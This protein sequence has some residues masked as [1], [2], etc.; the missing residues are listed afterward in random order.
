MSKASKRLRRE[1]VSAKKSRVSDLSIL[2][3]GATLLAPY[4]IAQD[5][6]AAATNTADDEV[7]RR[8]H[9]DPRHGHPQ[10]SR[11]IAG[12]QERSR[13]RGRLDH[14]VR[15]RRVPRQER[16]RSPAARDRHHRDAVRRIRRH[17]ALLRRAFGRRSS[18]ACR[19]CAANS[20]AAT[21][22]TRTARAACRSATSRPSSWRASTP[23][24]TATADMIEGGI[25]GTVNLRTH[26]PF[27]SEGFV[28]AFSG[29]LGY[30]DLSEEAK[31]SGSLI[32]S[33]RWDTG[34]GEFGLMANA[35][36]SAGHHR[37]AGH[38]ARCASS[39][40]R[41]SPLTA[42]APSGSRAASTF[43]TTPT[44]ARARVRRS[45][46]QW[47]SPDDTLLATVAVQPFRV[48]K[49]LGRVFAERRHRQL[50][51]SRRASSSRTQFAL[52]PPR[53]R[54]PY[55]FDSRGVFM[56][57][58]INDDRCLGR[59]PTNNPYLQHPNGFPANTA[60]PA[61]DSRRTAFLSWGCTTAWDAPP[62]VAPATGLLPESPRA[63]S[64]SA[65]TRASRRRRTPP[66]TLSLNLRGTSPKASASTSTS[67]RSIRRSSISTTARTTR[68]RTDL[69]LDISPAASRS[70]EFRAPRATA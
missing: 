66:K 24:R 37:I 25:A 59:A 39:A 17:H 34:I 5:Q 41:T 9:R 58:V 21:A 57:G 22:S 69:D 15:H 2:A 68:P 51:D 67:R 49:Q 6:D 18:A 55:E 44:T 1:A 45:P 31:P 16:R 61:P 65:P 28:V 29:E 46:R 27:D 4:A 63:A 54:R 30:G 13:H 35:A 38:A 52:R 33:N 12:N 60:N 62:M 14:R 7:R 36:Y 10:G 26:V 32:V 56:S 23:T 40:S 3:L 19:R 43:A 50:A 47:A 8:S 11:D 20:T 42:A 70:F 53:A 48:R 64:A